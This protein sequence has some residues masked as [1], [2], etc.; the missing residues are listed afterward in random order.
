VINLSRIEILLKDEKV[1]SAL[2]KQVINFK[3]KR[4]LQRAGVNADMI[5]WRK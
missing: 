2:E 5:R 4:L 1:V 3:L